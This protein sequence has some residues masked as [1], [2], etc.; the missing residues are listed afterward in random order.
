MT[1][2]SV[3]GKRRWRKTSSTFVKLYEPLAQSKSHQLAQLCPRINRI[4]AKPPV[5]K[6]TFGNHSEKKWS[7]Y[8]SAADNGFCFLEERTRCRADAFACYKRRRRKRRKVE[9]KKPT[10]FRKSVD[11]NV[12]SYFSPVIVIVSFND[13]ASARQYCFNS[14]RVWFSQTSIYFYVRKPSL[15]RA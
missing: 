15:S 7:F 9:K 14:P 12:I 4:D 8:I 13:R 5:W 11:E 10:P 3:H 2:K 1:R 6:C